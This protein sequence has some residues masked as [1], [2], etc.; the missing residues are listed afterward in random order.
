MTSKNAMMLVL[1]Y[2][3]HPETAEACAEFEE[4]LIENNIKYKTHIARKRISF[5]DDYHNALIFA[6]CDKYL[7]P[8]FKSGRFELRSKG[9]N[10][11]S[12]ISEV[13]AKQMALME[14]YKNDS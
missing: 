10:K 2:N 12:I 7:T 14:S 6:I 4:F 1:R 9:L 3:L 11:V 8:S 5:L 13:A